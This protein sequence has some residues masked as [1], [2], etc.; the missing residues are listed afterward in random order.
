MQESADDAILQDGYRPVYYITLDGSREEI[1]DYNAID[2][3]T[4]YYNWNKSLTYYD[5]NDGWY[6]VKD[7]GI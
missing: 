2:R 4:N 5:W 7:P 3:Y 6:V 1:T